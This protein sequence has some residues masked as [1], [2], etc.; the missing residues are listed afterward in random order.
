MIINKDLVSKLEVIRES[1][2]LSVA[3]FAENYLKIHPITY[4]KVID[5]KSV[6][7]QTVRAVRDY[8]KTLPD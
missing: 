4:K 5:G 3:D 6:N 2:P 1:Y 8:L 7:Y